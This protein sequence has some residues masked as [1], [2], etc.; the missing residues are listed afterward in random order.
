MALSRP[1]IALG[2]DENR[3]KVC[4]PCG[5]KLT[6]KSIQPI[7][8]HHPALIVKFLNPNYDINDPRYPIGISHAC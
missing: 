5:R 4:G 3:K 6:V 1:K 7:G 2:H 8:K